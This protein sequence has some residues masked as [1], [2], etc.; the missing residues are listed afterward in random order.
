MSA[1]LKAF[2]GCAS[3]AAA[4]FVAIA[5][6]QAKTNILLVVDGSNSMWGQIDNIAKMETARDTLSKLITDLPSGAD[7]GLMAYGHRREGDCEDV[8]LMSA[9]GTDAPERIRTLIGSI[10]PR[11]KTP[12]ATALVRAR[13][14]FSG[15]EGQNNHVLL[16]SDGIES[17][18]GNPCDVAKSLREAGL[19]VSAHVVGFGVSREEGKQLT[20]IAENT[21]GRYFDVANTAAFNEAIEEVTQIAQADTTQQ[22]PAE[23]EPELW[24]EDNF[25]GEDLAEHWEIIHPDPDYYIVEDGELL[26]ITG[27]NASLAGDNVKNL[28]RLTKDL[29]KGD[30]RATLKFSMDFQTGKESIFF[31]LYDDPENFLVSELFPVWNGNGSRWYLRVARTKMLK[32]EKTNSNDN[33]WYSGKVKQGTM[34]ATLSVVQPILMRIEKKGRNYAGAIRFEGVDDPQWIELPDLKLLRQ[35]GNLTFG[36][37]KFSDH[38]DH[39]GESS[40]LV[41]EI[42]IETLAKP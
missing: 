21:G 36:V 15:R 40:I 18:D 24:L 14:A 11:G 4:A 32:G 27:K 23:P 41:D 28:F 13:D 42:K 6:V 2:T 17:C 10:Q 22:P 29:P 26:A 31:G 33:V 35:K 1:L 30:W 37:Y 16:V 38:R 19:N 25:D 8:E 12:I 9:L 39:A 20:C 34:N 7:L 5:P 3:I